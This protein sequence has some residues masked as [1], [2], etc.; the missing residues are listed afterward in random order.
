MHTYLLSDEDVRRFSRGMASRI[1]EMGTKAPTIWFTLGVSGDKMAA[2]IGK[3]LDESARPNEVYKL[4]CTR[5][6]NGI[7][8]RD[9]QPAQSHFDV[10]VAFVVDSAIHSG[11]SFT[12]AANFLIQK[13]IRS[14]ISYSLVVK[15]SSAFIPTY[16]GLLIGEHDRAYFQLDE[17]PSN[18]LSIM[19]APQP[20]YGHMRAISADDAKGP[21]RHLNTGTPSIDAITF[22]DLWYDVRAHGKSVYFFEV[23]SEIAGMVT[24]KML[25][26]GVMLL[27]TIARDKRFKGQDVGGIMWRWAETFARSSRCATI[28][29]WAIQNKIGWYKSLGFEEVPNETLDLGPAEKYQRM[30][31]R[32]LYNVKPEDLVV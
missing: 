19:R 1:I 21:P 16:F 13:G 12:A 11:A 23:G 17:I 8:F 15:R 32:I 30:R 28:D 3:L 6:A 25:P 18:R 20:P 26:S 31:R 29:L 7:F 14:I 10:E 9:P 24:F 27:D 2:E 22:A 4:G 5:P